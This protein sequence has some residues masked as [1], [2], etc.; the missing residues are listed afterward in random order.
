MLSAAIVAPWNES[1]VAAADDV[2]KGLQL[3]LRSWRVATTAT[4]NR[5]WLGW[6]GTVVI[7]LDGNYTA[8]D[9]VGISALRTAVHKRLAIVPV[10]LDDA[11]MPDPATLPDDLRHFPYLNAVLGSRD[12]LTALLDNVAEAVQTPATHEEPWTPSHF[13]A[14]VLVHAYPESLRW[15]CLLW[16]GMLAVFAVSRWPVGAGKWSMVYAVVAF[17]IAFPLGL[18]ASACRRL[19]WWGVPAALGS[20]FVLTL[21]MVFLTLVLEGIVGSLLGAAGV[22]DDAP[23]RTTAINSVFPALVVG[24]LLGGRAIGHFRATP[25]LSPRLQAVKTIL[26]GSFIWLLL[27]AGDYAMRLTAAWNPSRFEDWSAAPDLLGDMAACISLLQFSLLAGTWLGV[28]DAVFKVW[29]EGPRGT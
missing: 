14:S 23:A 28:S 17:A 3:R 26:L 27:V 25:G 1:A 7:V 12:H 8:G 20:L 13:V 22:S 6:R 21:G 24:T 11:A 16:G 15:S 18:F 10:L 2:Q 4:A 19:G 29:H 5:S 9:A